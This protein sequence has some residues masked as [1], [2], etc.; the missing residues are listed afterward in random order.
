MSERLHADHTG[1]TEYH[2]ENSVDLCEF[3]QVYAGEFDVILRYLALLLK[4]FNHAKKR[5]AS[6]WLFWR[7]NLYIK[8]YTLAAD[9]A[10][11]C[12]SGTGFFTKFIIRVLPSGTTLASVSL[13]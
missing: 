12:G 13:I 3:L 4:A 11:F 1:F 9:A 5:Q 2:H 10:L 7:F 8:M 6:L